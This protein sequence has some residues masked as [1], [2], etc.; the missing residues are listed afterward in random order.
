MKIAIVTP[1]YPNAAEPNAG[2]IGNHFQ[3][4]ALGFKEEGHKVTVFQFPYV[5]KTSN[6]FNHHGIQVRQYGVT[7]PKWFKMRGLGRLARLTGYVKRFQSKHLLRRTH[8]VLAKKI[9]QS[10]FDVIEA[11]SNRGLPFSYSRLP[12]R[13]IPMI[14]RVSTTMALHFEENEEMPDYNQRKECE[15]ERG[16]I[17]RSDALVTHTKAHAVKLEAELGVDAKRFHIIPHGIDIPPP[18]TF[19]QKGS[20]EE[21]KVLFVGR[22]ESRKG[23]DVLL[24]AIPKILEGHPSTRFLL[25]G[26]DTN[27]T[28]QMEFQAK[29]DPIILKQVEFLGTVTDDERTRLYKECDVFVAPSMYESFGIVYAEAMSFGK[30]VVACNTGGA[31]EVIGRESGLLAEPGDPESLTQCVLELCRNAQQRNHMGQDGYKRVKAL[32]SREKMAKDTLALY[33]RVLSGNYTG[34]KY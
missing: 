33:H 19:I 28:Y 5:G 34:P 16:T 32:F 11:T 13:Q 1:F 4:L 3:H 6:S 27:N 15:F 2:G 30:A 29:E 24:K 18:P 10:G 21:V 20:S 7:Q 12:N 31:P 17:S 9:P 26:S 25:A 22:F 14:T 8:D 23:A